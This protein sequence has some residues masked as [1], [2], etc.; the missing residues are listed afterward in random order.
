[1]EC[2]CVKVNWASWMHPTIRFPRVQM[3]SQPDQGSAG[4]QNHAIKVAVI[5]FSSQLTS[6]L[7]LGLTYH[8]ELI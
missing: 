7:L 8:F 5:P 6:F 4:M 3:K 1:M 2:L